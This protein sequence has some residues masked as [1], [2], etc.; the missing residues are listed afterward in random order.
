MQ[1]NINSIL[2]FRQTHMAAKRTIPFIDPDDPLTGTE[3]WV[4]ARELFLKKYAEV[5]ARID[6]R[7]KAE[8]AQKSENSGSNP[9][10]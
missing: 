4:P 6:A 1:A 2:L 7:K 10:R 9:D 3:Q 8:S 5:K